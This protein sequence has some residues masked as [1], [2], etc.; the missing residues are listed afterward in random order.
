M[1]LIAVSDV[2]NTIDTDLSSTI[3]TSMITTADTMVQNGPALSTNPIL[4]P[5]ELFQIELYLTCH[6]VNLRDPIALQAKIGDSLQRS[7]P[8]SVTTAWG[9]GLK[10]TVFGQMA[11]VLDRSGSLAKLG[12]MKGS[13]RAAPRED[14]VHFTRNLTKDGLG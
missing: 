10:Q 9:Q 13:M 2:L 7:F 5:A 3:I 11:I 12:L 1:A 4:A 8:E 14:G 6:F